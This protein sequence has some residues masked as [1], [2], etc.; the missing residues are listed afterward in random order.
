VKVVR[1]KKSERIRFLKINLGLMVYVYNPS[2][3]E[4]EAGGSP[5]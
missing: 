4:A 3:W 2:T 1:G 5:V